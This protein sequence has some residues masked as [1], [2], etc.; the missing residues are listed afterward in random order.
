MMTVPKSCFACFTFLAIF[1][2]ICDRPAKADESALGGL[3]QLL[4]E[5]DDAAFQLDLLTGMHDALRG[6]KNVQM[7]P[8]WKDAYPKLSKSE[9]KE[10]RD[11]A[12][13]IALIF[14]DPQAVV[15]LK[16]TMMNGDAAAADRESAIRSLVEIGSKDM[17]QDLHKLVQDESVRAAAIRALAAVSHADTAEVI[18]RGYPG[19]SAADKQ[20]AVST[21]AARPSSAK[22]LLLAIGDKKIPPSDVHSFTARQIRDFGDEELAKLLRDSWG[23]VRDAS[24]DTKAMID[25][26]G[27]LLTPKTLAKADKQH[28]RLL[29][30]KT[31]S[32]CH[33][34]YGQGGKIGPDITG[35]N[36][37]SLF[38][39][40]ENILE[41]SAS[42]AKQYQ[43]TSV[44]TADGRVINGL[45]TEL[46]N[47]TVAIQTP[48]DRVILANEDIEERKLSDKSMMPDGLL[49]TL[50]ERDVAD[51]L[52]YL[53]TRSQVPLPAGAEQE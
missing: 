43:M 4:A 53:Q 51:L 26:F 27:K 8:G 41:P 16:K 15:T 38:Y 1:T 32:K 21:L 46:P 28:G 6:R 45:L 10:V 3:V 25:S 50:S 52:A 19:F 2:Q 23:E 33:L 44:A 22:Q 40:L 48:T 42:V 35:A 7:P 47:G 20:I 29:F 14:H 34:L 9:S 18:L 30:N 12:L 11:K 36:R 13:L 49:K 39:L 24:A 31:C 17:A 37:N 5:V